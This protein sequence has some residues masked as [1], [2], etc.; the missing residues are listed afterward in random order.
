[1]RRVQTGPVV[2]FVCMLTLVGALGATVGLS[3]VGWVFG[4]AYAVGSNAALARGIDRQRGYPMGPADWVTLT[5]AVLTGGVAALV[6]ESFSRSAPV[7]TLVTLSVFALILDAVD[8][9]VARRTG[10]MSA[11]GARFD[12]EV[13][14]FLILMLSLS[15]AHTTGWWWVFAIGAA[16]YVFVAAGWVLPWLHG[17]LPPRY[18]CKVV[19]ALE[20][21]VLTL[22]VADVLP[23]GLSKATLVVALILLTESFGRETWGLWRARTGSRHERNESSSADVVAMG[24]PSKVQGA[25][26]GHFRAAASRVTTVLACLA[27]WLALVLPNEI[28]GLT[29]ATFVRI[30]LEGL[31]IVALALVLG[32]WVSGTVAVLFGA[33]LGLL[34]TLKVL[35]M[36]FFAVFDRPFDPLNDWLYFQPGVGVLG[37]SIGHVGAMITVVVAA[38]LAVAILIVMP[39]CVVRL[40]RL[41]A[42]HRRGSTQALTAFGIVWA[43]CAVSG[44]QLAP[45]ARIASTSAAGLAYD[46]VTQVR[47]DIQDRETFAKAIT[48]DRFRDTPGD[49]LLTGLRGKDVMLVFVES[50]GRIAVQDSTFSPQVDAVLD[51]GTRRLR[52][53]GF[54]SRSA[55]LTSPTFGAGSWLAHS[56]LQSGLWVDSQQRYNQLLTNDRLTLTEAFGRAGWRTVSDVPADTQ[57]W[58][59][60]A[61]FYHFDKSYDA[62]NVGYRGPKFSYATMPDQ[63]TLSAFRRLELAKAARGPVMAEID[64]VSS[65][66]PWTPLPHLVN[67]GRV[68]DGSAFDAMPAQGE[69]PDVAFSD[70]GEVRAVY[71]QSIEYSLNALISFVHTYPDPNLVLIMLGDHQPHSYVSGDQPGHDVPI[72]IVAHDLAVMNRISGWGWQDGMRPSPD[73]PVW[74]MDTFRDRFLTAYGPQARPI[75]SPIETPSQH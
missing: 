60:G 17:S 49:Q 65:H 68:G 34:V 32:S 25:G 46:E 62:R 19:A 18:W 20:G 47:A 41:I 30:P 64:L 42:R 50:Y 13:D 73:A 35:D 5:R 31:V 61:S 3:S 16:R 57:D 37:D 4:V 63:Y 45:G 71:A 11:F 36:G 12:M 44:L 9:W 22:A 21:V 28:S 66:H 48:V 23:V 24:Q 58:P 55:F 53:A 51:A 59:E 75:P 1:M 14:A 26:R 69:S 43:L 10:T 74:R 67:W 70:P 15:V 40:T 6:A 52:A 2:G 29:P 7:V 8:G 72:T 38:A 54:S 56:T 33:V 39:L 27:V